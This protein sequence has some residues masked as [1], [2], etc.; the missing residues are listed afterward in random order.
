MSIPKPHFLLFSES[1]YHSE[2]QDKPGTRV[3]G[4]K[5]TATSDTPP[6]GTWRFQLEALDGSTQFAAAD[7]EEGLSRE[8][9]ELLSVIRGL[10][11]LEQPSRVTLVT[12]SRYVSRGIRF[13]IGSWRENDWRWENFG[14]TSAVPHSDLWQ[15][16]DRALEIHQVNCRFW[17]FDDAMESA[18]VAVTSSEP[19]LETPSQEESAEHSERIPPSQDSRPGWTEGWADLCLSWI[20]QSR[21]PAPQL[22]PS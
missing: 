20:G 15:R 8:R 17:K 9:L 16:V 12:R 7:E 13:G 6:G 3:T 19:V 21:T 10:E 5:S 22:C 11:A 1:H 2:M 4:K 14:T 18:E